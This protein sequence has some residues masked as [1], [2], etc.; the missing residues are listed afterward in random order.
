MSVQ[1]YD[2]VLQQVWVSELVVLLECR[3]RKQ[4]VVVVLCTQRRLGWGSAGW[5]AS[6]HLFER[7]EGTRALQQ[8]QLGL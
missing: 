5:G 4:R 8:P 6:G 7:S 1:E 3:G 2:R